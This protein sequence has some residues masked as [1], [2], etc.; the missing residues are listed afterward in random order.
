M[1]SIVVADDHPLICQA[2]NVVL[3]NNSD[4]QCVGMC[5]SLDSIDVT[6]QQGGVDVLVTDLQFDSGNA[7]QRIREWTKNQPLKVAVSSALRSKLFAPICFAEGAM[8]YIHKSCSPE[9]LLKTLR[10][11]SE[12]QTLEAPLLVDRSCGVDQVYENSE[13]ASLLDRLSPRELEVFSDLGLGFSTQQIAERHFVSEKTV[14]SHRRSIK[15]KLDIDSLNELISLAAVITTG[16][17]ARPRIER[18][19]S[20]EPIEGSGLH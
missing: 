17:H 10:R 3:G 9:T 15:K 5:H 6:L 7:I 18:D 8:A 19:Q 13:A 11:C 12:R 4:F 20:V 16:S 1:I 14:E 2:L